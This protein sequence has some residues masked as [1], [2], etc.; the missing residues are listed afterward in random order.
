MDDEKHRFVFFCE[1][2]DKTTT[3]L[4]NGALLFSI[5][6]SHLNKFLPL[7]LHNSQIIFTN[8]ILA[9]NSKFLKHNIFRVT[10]TNQHCLLLWLMETNFF[11]FCRSWRFPR[12]TMTFYLRIVLE[13]SS[14]IISYHLFQKSSSVW[15]S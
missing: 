10:V 8:D 9:L 13:E 15:L 4:L 6:G 14:L 3:V 1:I 5:F 12:T 2:H 11:R 7:M